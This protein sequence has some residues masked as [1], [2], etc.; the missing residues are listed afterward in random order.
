M[1]AMI[2]RVTLSMVIMVL[3]MTGES[4]C[5]LLEDLASQTW[6]AVTLTNAWSL[7]FDG[8]TNWGW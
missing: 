3:H 1:I 2:Q 5:L 8:K 4:A 7:V 6:R